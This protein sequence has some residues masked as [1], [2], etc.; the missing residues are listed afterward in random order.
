MCAGCAEP[1]EEVLADCAESITQRAEELGFHA[2]W[3]TMA[4]LQEVLKPVPRT[5]DR[6]D[7]LAIDLLARQLQKDIVDLLNLGIKLDK[8][9]AAATGAGI[10]VGALRAL[11][12][13]WLTAAIAAGAALLASAGVRGYKYVRFRQV[14]KKWQGLLSQMSEAQQMLFAEAMYQR[15]PALFQHLQLLLTAGSE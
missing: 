14:Q 8:G 10:S 9:A 3:L 2:G 12:G 11:G 13:H 6:E 5:T 4:Q 7:T 1:S 15:H